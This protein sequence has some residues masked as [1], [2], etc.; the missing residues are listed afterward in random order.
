MII[1]L[2][3][4]LNFALNNMDNYKE[5]LTAS[6]DEILRKYYTIIREYIKHSVETIIVNKKT[7][8][9]FIIT[10]GLDTITHVFMNLLY[11]TNNI[12]LVVYH[13]EKSLYFYIEFVSQISQEDKSFLELSSR[14][15][16]TYVYKKTIYDINNEKRKNKNLVSQLV[17]NDIRK[18]EHTINI[19]KDCMYKIIKTDNFD[20]SLQSNYELIEKLILKI[21]NDKLLI[22]ELV[23]LDKI[24]NITITKIVETSLF[25]EFYDLLL[26]KIIKNPSL[27]HSW[28]DIKFSEIVSKVKY[29]KDINKYV[30]LSLS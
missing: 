17:L 13:C 11:Y 19:F 15:A 30:N 29:Y 5:K 12:D 6:V 1:L 8:K 4:E 14:D 9:Q 7:L 21:D 23:L 28:D 2:N 10:R 22:D 16:T 20:T 18:I 24:T 26:K 25:I 3:K 27:L